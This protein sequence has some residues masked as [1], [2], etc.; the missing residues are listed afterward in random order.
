[1]TGHFRHPDL[2]AHE[3][4]CRELEADEPCADLNSA[5]IDVFCNCHHYTEPKILMN[6][7][8]IAWPAGWTQEQA[9]N[10]RVEHGLTP[11]TGDRVSVGEPMPQQS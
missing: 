6:G 2:D 1:M 5:Y 7:I 10:W 4:G 8:D 11:P 3:P 9:H